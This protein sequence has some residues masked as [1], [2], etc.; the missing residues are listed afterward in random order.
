MKDRKGP[1][2]FEDR[3]AVLAKDYIVGEQVSE[4]S[5]MLERASKAQRSDMLTD[6]EMG[7]VQAA[8]RESP[9]GFASPVFAGIVG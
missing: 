8:A 2:G 1:G 4:D 6:A 7:S 5:R 9:V 3:A